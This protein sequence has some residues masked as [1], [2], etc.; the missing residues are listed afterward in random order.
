MNRYWIKKA[1][2]VG[3]ACV[4]AAGMLAGCGKEEVSAVS[5]SSEQGAVLPEDQEL[6]LDYTSAEGL[7]VEPGT[8]VAVVV[9]GLGK[10]SY[11]DIIRQ[12][13]EAAVADVNELQGFQGSDKVRLTFEGPADEGNQEEQINTLDT[14]LADNPA[15]LCLAAIDMESCE[16]QLETAHDNGIPVLILDTGIKSDLVTA[17]CQTDNTAAGKAAGKKLCKK[18]EGKGKVAVV[19]HLPETETSKLRVKGFKKALKKYPDVELVSVLEE[20]EEISM[21]EQL[22]ELKEQYPDL[23]GIFVTNQSNAAE[24]LMAYEGEE[25]SPVIVGFDNGEK[26]IQAI[27]EGREYG[28]ISQN[29]YSMGYAVVVAALRAANGEKVDPV[30]DS[31]YVWIDET[32]LDAPENQ[33]YLYQ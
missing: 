29:P 16:A 32:N 30:I 5:C 23:D 1:A 31:G 13:V 27:R 11:W 9:K 20:N 22:E 33:R 4:L 3:T 8:Y 10:N 21:E 15:V 17:V 19:S 12:G 26:Q 14:V 2:A 25:Q 18:L 24:V 6:E 7:T 28:C